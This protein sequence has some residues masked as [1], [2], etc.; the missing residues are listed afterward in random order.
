MVKAIL[1]VEKNSGM[2]YN[3]TLP[4]PKNSEDLKHFKNKTVG[5]TVVMGSGTWNDKCFPSPL[6]DRDNFVI[7]SKGFENY[8]GANVLSKNIPEFIQYID[9]RNMMTDTWII[10]G[11]NVLEQLHDIIDEYHI[12]TINGEYECDVFFDLPMNDFVKASSTISTSN[13]NEYSVFKRI[14]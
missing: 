1:A 4:W 10:G 9:S 13:G 5:C 12:T 3:G 14:R 2:G 11:K 6:K 7:S 8:K